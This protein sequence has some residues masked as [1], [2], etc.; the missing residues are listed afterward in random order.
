M[1]ARADRVN[2]N[3]GLNLQRWIVRYKVALDYGDARERRWPI[4][5]IEWNGEMAGDMRWRLPDT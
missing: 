1:G 3:S 5:E 2:G 4:P